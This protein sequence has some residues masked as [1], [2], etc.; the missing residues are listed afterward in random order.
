MKA[1]VI[2]EVGG[3]EVLKVEEREIPKLEKS[4]ALIKIKAFGLNRSEMFTR[5]G[6]SKG[7]VFFPRILGIECVG[8]VVESDSG[9]YKYGQQVAVIMRGLGRRLD[10]GYAE[11]TLAPE[12]ILIPFESSLDWSVLGAIPE[13]CQTAYGSLIHSL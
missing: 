13:M 7:K 4:K 6:H 5:L 9:K 12:G 10:G 2:H 1:I 8:T 3:P 11:Y